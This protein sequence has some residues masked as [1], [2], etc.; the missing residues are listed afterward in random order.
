M[1][2][3]PQHTPETAQGAS[4][5][6]DDATL[7]VSGRE[8][9]PQF[10]YNEWAHLENRIRSGA[11]WFFWIA[12][13]SIINSVILLFSGKWSFL[14]GLGITQVIDGLAYNISEQL[15]SAVTVFAM[16]LN[17]LVAG[18]FVVFGLQAKK[19][20]NW[21]F[22][23]GMV[24]YGLDATIFLLVQGWLSIAFHLFALYQIY[25]GLSANNELKREQAAA[26]T[27]FEVQG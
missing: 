24:I 23:T 10:M 20:Q 16:G 13:L 25:R 21:A 27:N 8:P 26:A 11:N 14:A 3:D 18:A 4:P 22:I 12:A 2:T 19:K 7:K 15:G 6:T 1:N 17:L 5:K 9:I